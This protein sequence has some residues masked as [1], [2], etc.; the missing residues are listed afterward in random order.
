MDSLSKCLFHDAPA[1]RRDRILFEI[2]DQAYIRRERILIFAADEERAAQVD[3]ML[4][5]LKQEAFIPHQ[6]F[7]SEQADAGV[8]VGIVTKEINPVKARILIA[9]GHC[10]LDFACSFEQV[11]EFVTRTTPQIHEACRDRFRSYR[12]RNIAVEHVKE[13]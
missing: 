4:W 11:H 8:P 1:D 7:Q 5:I 2:A 3:R 10:S 6:V 9:D 12:V 13:N